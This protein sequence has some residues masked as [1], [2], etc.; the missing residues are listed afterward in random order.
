M[1]FSKLESS[2]SKGT[3]HLAL[4][5]A[6]LG[7]LESWLSGAVSCRRRW[8][9]CH[10]CCLW[11]LVASSPPSRPLL[12]NGNHECFCRCRSMISECLVCPTDYALVDYHIPCL[13]AIQASSHLHHQPHPPTHTASS[14]VKCAEWESSDCK[15]QLAGSLLQLRDG[16]HSFL[17]SAQS[18]R[19]DLLCR[20]LDS[21]H[22]E[23][24]HLQIFRLKRRHS[25]RYHL[26]RLHCLSLV[27]PCFLELS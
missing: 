25:E 18:L 19:M 23:S 12:P 13:A 3:G 26:A 16:L 1:H 9:E 7:L 22:L 14:W 4:V 10:G 21:H 27:S 24:N 6:A 17:V 8:H 5:T 15:P 2:W 20:G 11:R